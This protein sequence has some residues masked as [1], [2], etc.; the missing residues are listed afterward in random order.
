[1]SAWVLCELVNNPAGSGLKRTKQSPDATGEKTRC[2]L[3]LAEIPG[4]RVHK[5]GEMIKAA[6][7]V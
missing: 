2:S 7:A 3:F 6:A 4:L 5:P 1:M